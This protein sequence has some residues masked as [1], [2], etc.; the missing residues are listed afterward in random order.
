MRGISFEIPNEHSNYLSTILAGIPIEN[1]EWIVDGWN[2]S[3]IVENGNLENDLFTDGKISGELLYILISEQIYYLIA[4][5]LQAFSKNS[6]TKQQTIATY[7]QF[8]ESECQIVLL[9]IDSTFLTLYVKD[10]KL[11]H[12]I[13]R[14]AVGAGFKN[15]LYIT[16]E[17]DTNTSLLT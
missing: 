15:I 10:Q 4:V 3:Y 1:Y 5:T 17:N 9:V 7:E 8:L 6:L 16:E 2:E 14:N 13:Q 12:I 11:L